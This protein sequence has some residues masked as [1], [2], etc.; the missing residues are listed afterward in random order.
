MPP[1]VLLKTPVDIGALDTTLEVGS[2]SSP[3]EQSAI[4]QCVKTQQAL[5]ES[6]QRVAQTFR[7]AQ[8]WQAFLAPQAAAD[9]QGLRRRVAA[10]KEKIAAAQAP[11]APL[12]DSRWIEA[13]ERLQ[14]LGAP[15]KTVNECVRKAF[16]PIQHEVLRGQKTL[17]GLA[18]AFQAWKARLQ[19][20][21]DRIT[22]LVPFIQ[23]QLPRWEAFAGP[24][25]PWRDVMDLYHIAKGD[26]DWL[27]PEEQNAALHRLA[28]Q[29]QVFL[30]GQ[31]R[32]ALAQ[33]AREV[34]L[35]PRELLRQQIVLA[36]VLLVIAESDTSQRLQVGQTRICTPEGR[37]QPLSPSSLLPWQYMRWFWRQVPKAVTALLLDRPYPQTLRT[38]TVKRVV[39]EVVP[40]PEATVQ[41][42]SLLRA[43]WDVASP[44]QQAILR[45]LWDEEPVN[46]IAALLGIS[47]AHVYAQL[48]RLQAKSQD[49]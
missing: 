5:Q 43:V 36:A 15:L 6:I 20:V 19:P 32:D 9:T 29:A 21:I 35:S 28:A 31:A 8:A 46:H 42:R 11:I 39:H 2:N 1:V 38:P 7:A 34:H 25:T 12:I 41:A 48:T 47:R 4:Q 44:Q 37:W 49:L 33:R 16:Q 27:T 10:L 26:H 40:S 14:T 3:S 23:S 45:L 22:S 18:A 24:G 30:A 13:Q 17:Q